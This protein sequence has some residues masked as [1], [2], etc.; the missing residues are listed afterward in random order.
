M[1]DDLSPEQRRVGEEIASLTTDPDAA[2]QEAIMRAVMGAIA[3][4][5]RRR[6]VHHWRLFT[7]A[8]ALL[9]LLAL[10]SVGAVAATGNA[11][12]TTP[13]Y[14]VRL[15]TEDIRLATVSSRERDLL[16]IR[17]AVDR[18]GQ[19]QVIASNNLS[20][21]QRLFQDGWRYLMDAAADVP[22]LSLDEQ[23]EVQDKL[24]KAEAD[25]GAT[26]AVLT[27]HRSSLQNHT[28]PSGEMAQPSQAV[29]PSQTGQPGQTA[30]PVQA[31]QSGQATPQPVQTTQPGETPQSGQTGQSGQ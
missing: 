4:A 7:M 6:T 3:P 22:S 20:A 27:Q 17:F 10:G 13:A 31:G 29:Q 24:E 5:A 23:F 14:Q 16:R 25:A 12:P 15:A 26:Q 18:F 30:Q 8:A 11:L 1:S 2:T 21:A 19:S 9:A 28:T